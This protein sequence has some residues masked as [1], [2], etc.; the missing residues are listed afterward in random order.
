MTSIAKPALTYYTLITRDEPGQPWAPQFGDFDRDVVAEEAFEYTQSGVAKSDIKIIKSGFAQEEVDRAVRHVQEMAGAAEGDRAECDV[1][2]EVEITDDV[3][4]E[5]EQAISEWKAEAADVVVP[6]VEVTLRYWDYNKTWEL[7]LFVWR[8]TQC[9]ALAPI[10]SASSIWGLSRALGEQTLEALLAMNPDATVA[11][12]LDAFS[13]K[14]LAGATAS[15]SYEADAYAELKAL[16]DETFAT[17][18]ARN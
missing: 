3:D 17:L 11:F 14:A 4:A 7:T 5:V 16:G 12:K 10:H 8:G 1:T 2:D 18:Q 6:H 13:K 15:S 9:V